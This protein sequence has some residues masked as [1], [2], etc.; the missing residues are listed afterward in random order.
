MTERER[1]TDRMMPILNPL[2]Y[3]RMSTI[4][5]CTL[6]N[7]L[8]KSKIQ[9][10]KRR[11]KAEKG[12]SGTVTQ[13]NGSAKEKGKKFSFEKQWKQLLEQQM[14]LGTACTQLILHLECGAVRSDMHA[15]ACRKGSE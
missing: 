11:A 10:L 15:I 7:D 12:H 4:G 6:F 2:G 1:E 14:R 5:W 13:N 3:A 9:S 8:H